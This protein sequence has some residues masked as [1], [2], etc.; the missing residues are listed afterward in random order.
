MD[1]RALAVFRLSYAP[2]VHDACCEIPITLIEVV[3]S[4]RLVSTIASLKQEIVHQVCRVR[5]NSKLLKDA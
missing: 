5:D 4:Y 2:E 1:L 3:L